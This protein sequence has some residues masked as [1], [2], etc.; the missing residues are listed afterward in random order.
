LPGA[1]V[2][3]MMGAVMRRSAQPFG[4]LTRL[5]VILGLVT[6]FAT[7]APA[8]EFTNSEALDRLFA[9]L[10]HAPDAVAANRIDQQI[11]FHWM[12]P[13]DPVLRG[14]MD[15]V[16]AARRA[17]DA[18]EAILLLNRIIE[19]Y[20]GYAEAWN[21]RATMYYV[22]GDFE[23][24]IADCAKVLE[25]EPRHFG[26]LSGRATIY[27]LQGKRAL[28][29]KDMAAA[30]QVHPF[31]SGRELFPELGQREEMTRI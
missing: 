1:T 23:A 25:L 30:L 15:E 11:W 4:L 3:Q 22:I 28:A 10:R 13:E 5:I 26:A 14:R 6:A 2:G 21:Q 8:D 7:P 27:L 17:G 9:E 20:P 29:L 18:I 12:T 31:I 24:S 16:L 19:D